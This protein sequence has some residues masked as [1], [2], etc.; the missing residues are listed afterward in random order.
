VYTIG[1]L[2]LAD[3]KL[4][5]NQNDKDETIISSVK[6]CFENVLYS[7]DKKI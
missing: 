4:L 3:P 6:D 2:K 5:Y 7:E 1:T